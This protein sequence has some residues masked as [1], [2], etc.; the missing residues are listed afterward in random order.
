MEFLIVLVGS[1]PEVTIVNNDEKPMSGSDLTLRCQVRGYPVPV[2]TWRKDDVKMNSNNRVLTKEDGEL[3]LK[4][5]AQ[6]DNGVYS[7]EASNDFG[8]DREQV[9]ISVREP[10]TEA[11]GKFCE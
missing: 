4:G 7:C 10:I 6:I 9:K 8:T 11:P 3:F 1:T 2:I 5:L